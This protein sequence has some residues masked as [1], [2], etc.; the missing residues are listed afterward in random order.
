MEDVYTKIFGQQDLESFLRGY[1][2]SEQNKPL[3]LLSKPFSGRTS[4]IYK[5]A[6]ELGISHHD[7][8]IRKMSLSNCPSGFEDIDRT[9]NNQDLSFD[10]WMLLNE[11]QEKKDLK[12]WGAEERKYRYSILELEPDFAFLINDL[13]LSDYG[14]NIGNIYKSNEY[15]IVLFI[16]YFDNWANWARQSGEIHP[17]VIRFAE[18]HNVFYAIE[19]NVFNRLSQDFSDYIEDVKENKLTFCKDSYDSEVVLLYSGFLLHL[20]YAVTELFW[21]YIRDTPIDELFKQ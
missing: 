18:K 14:K 12:K 9:I 19:H 21:D 1:F 15:S 5:I 6:D 13:D 17:A 3:V 8:E 11:I 16:P 7:I 2:S 20:G 4:V 10:E